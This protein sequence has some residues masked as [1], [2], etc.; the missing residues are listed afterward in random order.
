MLL[1]VSGPCVRSEAPLNGLCLPQHAAGHMPPSEK[2][3]VEASSFL[4]RRQQVLASQC[5]SEL[6][7]CAKEHEL[8]AT[9]IRFL[10][11][12]YNRILSWL[13]DVRNRCTR[14]IERRRSVDLPRKAAPVPTGPRAVSQPQSM[15]LATAKIEDEFEE[16]FITR[17]SEQTSSKQAEMETER[18]RYDAMLRSTRFEHKSRPYISL[19]VVEK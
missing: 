5:S 14:T 2:R 8:H 12:R 3:L 10:Q 4:I 16:A 7:R 19:H 13:D 17:L 6:R 1:P 9:D 11:R 15:S 18:R